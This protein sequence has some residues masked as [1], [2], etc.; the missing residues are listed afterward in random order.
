M[1]RK[2]SR[3]KYN[4]KKVTLDGVTFDSKAEAAFYKIH[5]GERMER[6]KKFLLAPAH[7]VNGIK[8]RAIYYIADFV[9]YDENGNIKKVI[10]VKGVTTADF[11]IKAKL[12]SLKY[13]MNITLAS[14]NG[15]GGKFKEK[16]I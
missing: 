13:Q 8:K 15:D 2:S 16:E 5:R 14:R 1:R 7:E 4:A 12:F 11:K 3:T 9:F 10:D 6:Q